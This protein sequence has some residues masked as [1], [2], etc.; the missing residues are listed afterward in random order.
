M[1]RIVYG[2][3]GK[4]SVG[5]ATSIGSFL[6]ILAFK[7][8]NY[9]AKNPIKVERTNPMCCFVSEKDRM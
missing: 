3:A 6:H 5:V 8:L 1:A 7:H 2:V 4:G 9:G